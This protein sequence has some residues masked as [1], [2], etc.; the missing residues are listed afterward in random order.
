MKDERDEAVRAAKASED[1]A[2]ALE[3]A[4]KSESEKALDAARKEGDQAATKRYEDRI[5]RTEVRSA[6]IAEGASA[7]LVDLA[8]RADEFAALKI[9]ESGD[10]EGLAPAIKKFKA[11]HGDL[12]GKPR[13]N[14]SA[15]LGAGSGGAPGLTLDEVRKMSPAEYATRREEVQAFL[16]KPR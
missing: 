16:A 3:D 11:D 7:T 4:T 8:A 6:L 15:D 2:K 13:A 14:G 5:R 12:F 1:R 10:V 9:N